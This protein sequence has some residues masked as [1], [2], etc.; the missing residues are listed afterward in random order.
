VIPDLVLS[1][2]R[3]VTPTGLRPATVEVTGGRITRV[4]EG[5]H[6]DVRA[7]EVVSLAD[8]E[9]LIPGLVD[10]HVHIN[11]PGRT[12]WEGFATA[13]RAAA[14]G[15]ITTLLDMPLNSVPVTTTAEALQVKRAAADGQCWVDVGF[16][17]GAV[18]ENLT[19]LRAL[20]DAG[21]F[22]FKCFLLDSG[23]AEFPPLTA[24]QLHTAMAE[25]AAFD[26]LLIIHAEDP[27][28]VVG[29]G[30]HSRSYQDFLAT[31]PPS[32]ETAAITTVIE[33]VRATGCRAHIVHLS[34]ADALQ[35]IADAKAEGLPLTVETCPHY[36]TLSAEDIPDG[37]TQFKCC[38]PV[39]ERRNADALWQALAEGIIDFIVSDHSPSPP[40]LKALETGDFGAAWG[41]I[42]SL[43]LGLPLIWTEARRRGHT[44][45]QVVGWMA[46]KPAT[47]MSVP[48]RGKIAEDNHADL[49][50]FAPD[51][52][53]SVD[54]AQLHHRHPLTPY[55]GREV[56]GAVG[57]TY[58][59][60]RRTHVEAAPTGVPLGRGHPRATGTP[61]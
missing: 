18:P 47:I 26:G 56:S 4:R 53:W 8:D 57:A 1:G 35:H 40:E 17:G 29:G 41:G 11:E 52:T 25:I 49:V 38:P 39:R 48:D 45:E 10:T 43:Q 15:G 19:Q 2:S 6:E 3:V 37:G 34:S 14:S 27:G 51:H 22:G 28:L 36:L 50:V 5:L 16:W 20:W 30:L 12:N 32:S 23:V 7:A 60:G 55:H 9:V 13:T 46:T 24:T 59:R 61:A 44:L 33:A 21:V 58:L 31:R 42:S 54:A